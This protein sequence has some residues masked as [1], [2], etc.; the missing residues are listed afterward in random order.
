LTVTVGVPAY[1]L[2]M[3]AAFDGTRGTGQRFPD[4]LSGSDGTS[5]P[6]VMMPVLDVYPDA[7]SAPMPLDV[8]PLVP[9]PIPLPPSGVRADPVVGPAGRPAGP[10]QR[11]AQRQTGQRQSGQRS[12]SRPAPGRQSLTAQ[13]TVPARPQVQSYRPIAATPAPGQQGH[14]ISWQ[15]RS[16]S[17]AD[18]ASMV[19]A[20]LS[21]QPTPQGQQSFQ[22]THPQS[23][24]SAAPPAVAPAAPMASQYSGHGQA[25]N[26]ARERSQERR[27]TAVPTTRRSSSIWA[28]LVF[29]VVIL[30]A[31]GLGQQIIEL[32]TELLNR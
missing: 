26:D 21:G 8:I 2:A 24:G 10:S 27:R 25:R 22:A 5:D 1:H 29:M 13:T 14:T 31:T 15:G 23:M 3:T 7:L 4:A 30:F 9:L 19:R 20:S 12:A 28:V 16:M 17:A 32:I 6:S 18:I 11:A